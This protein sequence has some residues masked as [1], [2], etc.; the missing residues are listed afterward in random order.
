MLLELIENK[1]I[2]KTKVTIEYKEKNDTINKLIDFIDRIDDIENSITASADGKLYNLDI[3]DILYIESVDRKTFCYT[4]DKIYELGCKLYDIEEKY[5]V[6]DY[7]RASK[8]CIINLK[9]VSSIKPD[10]GG[11]I[12]ALMDNGERIMISRQYSVILK[13]KLGLGGKRR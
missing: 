7:I 3:D 1:L 11:K 4:E 8:A 9:R 5:G 12:L 13:E 6:Y 10:F 2:K